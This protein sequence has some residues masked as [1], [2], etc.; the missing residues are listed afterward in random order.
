MEPN[1]N[2]TTASSGPLAA[3]SGHSWL[4]GWSGLAVCA[5]AIV[6]TILV[7][8]AALGGT[9]DA[10]TW[11]RLLFVLPCAIMMF[12]CMKNIGGNQGETGGS[13]PKTG[14]PRAGPDDGR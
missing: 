14:T 8:G 6:G 4:G 10:G 7:F 2:S 1:K 13:N 5:V 12:M 3:G 9:Q 11:L